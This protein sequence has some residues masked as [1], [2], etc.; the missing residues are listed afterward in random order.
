MARRG[1]LI[2]GGLAVLG[3]GALALGGS[4]SASSTPSRS[5][6]APARVG[7]SSGP[8]PGPPPNVTGDPAGYSTDRL[9]DPRSARSVLVSLGYAL[10]VNDSPLT[11]A[12]S[13]S[14]VQRFQG[15]Y[16][17]IARHIAAGHITP[18][19]IGGPYQGS[20]RGRLDADG[21]AGAFTHRGFE[22]AAILWELGS[23]DFR[24]ALALANQL[25]PTPE[26]TPTPSGSKAVRAVIAE[27]AERWDWPD[28]FYEFSIAAAYTESKFNPIV[29]NGFTAPPSFPAARPSNV[30]QE[31]K[32][33]EVKASKL[34]YNKNLRY[35]EDC[36]HPVA[37]YASGSYGLWG[38]LPGNVM[39]A[40]FETDRQCENPVILFQIG[41]AMIGHLAYCSRIQGWSTYY[42]TALATR[43]GMANPSDMKNGPTSAIAK[44]VRGRL[45]EAI[46][47]SG[48][49]ISPDTKIPKLP[50][51]RQGF[52]N[53]LSEWFE[54]NA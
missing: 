12:A 17:R 8:D 2:A 6:P 36:G 1:L 29:M 34:A 14:A 32:R 39:A 26:P 50:R 53:Q 40:W 52:A 3:V 9:P 38:A 4:A 46:A 21:D 43:V 13:R 16:S 48:A 23:L 31:I 27:W 15:D 22:I 25:E 49:N 18:T 35:F 30:S 7:G 45:E 19:S 33:N 47:A 51:S 11:D 37:D 42:G 24:V 28:A 41:P 5:K 54:A 44:R 10:P 20:F